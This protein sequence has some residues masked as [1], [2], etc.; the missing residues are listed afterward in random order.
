MSSITS[1]ILEEAK[2][3]RASGS[4]RYATLFAWTANNHRLSFVNGGI[5]A[6]EHMLAP[7]DH[8]GHD[9][10]RSLG[11]VQLLRLP[12]LQ[13]ED[14]EV[15]EHLCVWVETSDGQRF[16]AECHEEIKTRQAEE[17]RRQR[18]K[19]GADAS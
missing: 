1:P 11:G 14:E 16:V 2:R 9:R 15:I 19:M 13:R 4:R 17:Y 7:D 18:T 12:Y 6:I 8:F 5:R 10:F 3:L